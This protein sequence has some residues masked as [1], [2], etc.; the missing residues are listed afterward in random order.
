MRSEP[1]LVS[2]VVPVRN[3]AKDIGH[4]L[5]ALA[6]QSYRGDWELVVADNRCTDRS[7][8][9]VETF[10]AALPA[11]TVTDAR[12]RISIN[13]ARNAGAAAARGELLA[14]CDADDVATPGWLEA[15][16][17]GAMTADI[18]V[19]RVDLDPLNSSGPARAMYPWDPPDRL[20][21]EHGFLPYASGGNCGV[22]ANVA[23]SVQWDESCCFGNSDIEFSW[24]AQLAG[25]PLAFV[26][27]AVMQVRL[28][29]HLAQLARQH[30]AY[31]RSD[32]QLYRRFRGY[33]MVSPSYSKPMPSWRWLIASAGALR[34]TPSHRAKWIRVAAR[35]LGRMVGSIE[36]GVLVL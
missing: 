10:R 3:E 21:T 20:E 18:V 8:E 26:D 1:S 16:V 5:A 35:K 27:D 22:W 2:V 25:W 23:R 4:Q 32:P 28:N 9:I 6:G 17:R 13:H 7:I 14:F 11:M 34:G 36:H 24:R 19:G 29:G 31:G 15:L 12:E 33:G 30:Y